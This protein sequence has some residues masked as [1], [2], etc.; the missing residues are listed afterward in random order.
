MKNKTHVLICAVFC[1]VCL[2]SGC[3]Q[4]NLL[5][6]MKKIV[7]IFEGARILE[8]KMPTEKMSVIMMEVEA[9]KASQKEI[10]DFYKDAM[11]KQGWELKSH[12]DY[13]KNGS[14]MELIK[15][16]LGTLSVVTIMKKTPKTGK[17][18]VTLN[19]TVK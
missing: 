6:K 10:L 19:L 4:E 17:I 14:V 12:K 16:D 1:L 18:P 11:T 8:S 13:G 9:S 15:E 3:A 7:P 5:S 2:L